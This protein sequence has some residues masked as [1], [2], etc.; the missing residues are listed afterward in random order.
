VRWA[1]CGACCLVACAAI[2]LSAGP[3]PRLYTVESYDA[4]IQPDLTKQLLYGEVRIRFH[5][6]ADTA[7]SALELDAG[8]LQVKAVLEGQVSQYFE[9]KGSVV[10]VVLTNP[11]HADEH[12]TI[13]V[14]YQAGPGPGLKFYPDQIY[15][16]ATS[17][18]MP[19]ND[20]PGERSTLRLTI[21]A[22]PD[23]KAAG[24]GQLTATRSAEGKSVTEW[25]ITSPA[26][27]SLF[28]FALGSFT[29]N[30]SDAEDV[31]LRVL[32]AGAQIADPTAAAL[33]YLAERTG[34]K[35]PS[36][37][38]TQVFTHGDA[39]HSMAGLTLLPEAYAQELAKQPDHLFPLA[40]AL[41]HQWY[42]VAI[43]TKDWSDL[44]LSEGVSAFLA[45]GF[46][47]RKFGKERYQREIQHSREI[48]NQLRAEGKDRSLSDTD[49]N[50]R[51]EADGDIP[52]HKGAWFLYLVNEMVGE[53]TFWD[54]LRLYTSNEW[55]QAATSEDLQRAF[56]AAN[57]GVHSAEKK[58]GAEEHKKVSKKGD[59]NAPK[60]VDNL[61][62]LWV[63][64]VPNTTKSK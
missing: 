36:Q 31:K 35:Y 56:D 38:Y 28:G 26:E 29:E 52:E 37:S 40:N 21:F 2:P 50:T 49:W 46:L 43:A 64:G 54:G 27:P 47:G 48:H 41:A 19:C 13:T 6:E 57:T 63:F 60:T 24:S 15:T 32:G 9:R 20:R 42:G 53:T 11:L 12:R 3:V 7:I 18:W 45:D 14:Q 44:W 59:K 33:R 34:K 61:F 51:K 8:G 58:S 30:T 5:T 39:T 62:D 17:D 55:G 16:T 1:L 22:P 23:M 4:S 25:Q 10:V